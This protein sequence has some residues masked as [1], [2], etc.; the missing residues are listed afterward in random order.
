MGTGEERH[1]F[2]H[3]QKCALTQPPTH[4]HT[5]THVRRHTMK[6]EKASGGNGDLQLARRGS[7]GGSGEEN[8]PSTGMLMYENVTS[9]STTPYAN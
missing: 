8:E 9:N 2:S 1:I 4:I 6:A 7:K 5:Y 3:I